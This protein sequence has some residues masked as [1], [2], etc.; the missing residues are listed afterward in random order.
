MVRRT[1]CM[2]KYNLMMSV[3][4]AGAFDCVGDLH[5]SRSMPAP[6]SYLGLLLPLR[7][8]ALNQL[9]LAH[10]LLWQS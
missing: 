3:P 8:R 5:H 9:A 6:G 4:Q 1:D 7:L 10:F 2:G